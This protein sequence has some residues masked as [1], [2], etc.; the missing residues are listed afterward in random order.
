MPW[1]IIQRNDE[2]CVFR[3][4]EEG[5][6]VG[7]A[8]GC[9]PTEE[10]ANEQLKAL[11]ANV[12]EMAASEML[13]VQVSELRKGYLDIPLPSDVD[14]EA[15]G[16][17]PVFVTLPV[18]P[19]G[20]KSGNGRKYGKPFAA[21]VAREINTKRPEGGFGHLRED[22]R[23]T[24]YE[25]PDIRWLVA[26]QDEQGTTW[27]KG[28]A[29]TEKARSH[30][31]TAKATNSRVATSIYGWA[32]EKD[33]EAVDI[34]L[35][36]VDIADP[37]RAGIREAVALPIVT[38]EMEEELN[39]RDTEGTEKPEE[40]MVL[41]EDLDKLVSE[42][43]SERDTAQT[44]LANSKKLIAEIAELIPASDLVAGVKALVAE[45]TVL[46]QKVLSAEINKVIEDEVKLKDLRPIIAEMLGAVES[47]EQAQTRV[48][49]L[50]LTESI[51]RLAKALVLEMGGPHVLVSAQRELAKFDDTPEKRAAARAQFGF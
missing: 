47:K 26:K 35:E 41:M 11:N 15:L 17:D 18:M 14:V 21:A 27:A 33:G 9:H 1:K 12:S 48:R 23:A 40:E 38:K 22:E 2:F 10:A 30:F 24:K 44:D 28:I 45:T 49:E 20:T 32:S 43:R 37:S 3:H 39:H 25:P 5:N 51:Q 29:L 34:D 16:P 31:K 7:E 46:R 4:D 36:K 13:H 6:A 19:A 50:L 8:L 42:L